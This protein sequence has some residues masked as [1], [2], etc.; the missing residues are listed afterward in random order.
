MKEVSGA[1]QVSDA[2]GGCHGISLDLPE[3]V[4]LHGAGEGN[5]GIGKDIEGLRDQSYCEEDHAFDSQ[6]DLTPVDPSVGLA[7]MADPLG[8]EDP[9]P[10]SGNGDEIAQGILKTSLRG[11]D[12]HENE[13]AGLGIGENA[14]PA[15]VGVGV[16]KA[17]CQRQ[18]D[19][20][21]HGIR[22]LSAIKSF[23][24]YSHLSLRL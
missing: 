8:Q 2:H 19:T 7:Q 15:Y 17:A 21:S 4:Y 5:Q 10:K 9:R 24:I 11:I 18:K 14:A 22:H 3:A 23:H 12:A 13:I 6:D 1:A 20:H 16:L